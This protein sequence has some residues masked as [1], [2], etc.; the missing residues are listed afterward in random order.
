MSKRILSLVI[1]LVA[2]V[3]LSTAQIHNAKNILPKPTKIEMG[4]SNSKFTLS[5]TTKVVCK[6]EDK[7]VKYALNELNKLG[8]ELFGKAFKKG[9]KIEGANNIIIRNDN[10]IKEEGYH[11][12]ITPENII[13]KAKSA[14]GVFYA[15]QTI[16]QIVPV[17]AYETPIDLKNLAMPLLTIN[18]APHFGYRGFMLDC[19]RHFWDVETIKEM[20]D[21]L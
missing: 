1:A 19:S 14:A 7:N 10:S 15:V 6:L 3:S 13:I 5:P 17:Q 8:V 11:L 16:R 4:N 20:I 18:D 9:T 12:E 2:T 21:I